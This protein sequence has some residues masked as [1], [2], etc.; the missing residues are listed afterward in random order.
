[1]DKEKL[2]KLLQHLPDHPNL[3]GKKRFF[4]AA[5][6]IP[7]IAAGDEYHFLFQKRAANIRQGGEICFPG[8]E[9]EADTDKSCR[10]AAIRETTEE[11]GIKRDKI[12]IL[13]RLDTFISPRGITVD[14]FIGEL[15]ISDF[16]KLSP[17]ETEVEKVFS[18]PVSWF[19]ENPPEEY[20]LK[21][22]V[23]PTYLDQEGNR[24]DMLPIEELG[25]PEHYREPWPAINYRVLIYRSPQETVWGITAELVKEVV[26]KMG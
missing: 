4:N 15:L 19:E 5:V 9:F 13:G 17:D 6:L 11:L 21:L 14:S 12:N 26:E 22:Q 2:R 18:I 20:Q 24:V 8:G 7:I 25:L 3:M 1:M 10:E 23:N 16:S